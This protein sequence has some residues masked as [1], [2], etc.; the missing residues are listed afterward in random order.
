L[1]AGKCACKSSAVVVEFGDV[2]VPLR[3][4]VVRIDHDLASERLDWNLAI[5]LQRY[6]HDDDVPDLSGLV[7]GHRPGLGPQLLD[8]FG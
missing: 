5:V 6:G 2:A 1:E 8:E 4:V 7:R 3:V